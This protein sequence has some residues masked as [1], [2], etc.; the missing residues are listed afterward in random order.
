MAFGKKLIRYK[1]AGYLKQI[2]YI[3][4]EIVQSV[5]A[6]KIML[7]ILILTHK[8]NLS[9]FNVENIVFFLMSVCVCDENK[10]TN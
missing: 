2:L 3:S 10:N 1:Q 4:S 5:V 9:D 6:E 8:S 7:K